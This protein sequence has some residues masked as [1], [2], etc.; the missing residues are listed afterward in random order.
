MPRSLR[1]G[2]AAIDGKRCSM[3]VPATL[4]AT[5]LAGVP[6][7]GGA[8]RSGEPEA[9]ARGVPTPTGGTWLSGTNAEDC[10]GEVA[11]PTEAGVP[12]VPGVPGARGSSR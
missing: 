3:G 5:L 10:T 8:S 4:P 6:G 7:V 2:R 12:G 1:G 11:A 9:V